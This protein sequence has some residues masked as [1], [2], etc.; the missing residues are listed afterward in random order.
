M[1]DKVILLLKYF[2]DLNL[3]HSYG[4][5]IVNMYGIAIIPLL[6]QGATNVSS[7]WDLN[8][9]YGAFPFVVPALA[10]LCK[11]DFQTVILLNAVTTNKPT[12]VGTTN[13]G[14]LISSHPIN[15][16]KNPLLNSVSQNR[17][18]KRRIFC[19]VNW[20]GR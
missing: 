16:T 20:M 4:V 10:G 3:C 14:E 1:T 12:K 13:N 8:I 9:S 17:T 7:L 5:Q 18:L 15:L 2:R 19:Q 11:I 6:P